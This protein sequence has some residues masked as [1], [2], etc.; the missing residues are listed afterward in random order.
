M[1]K[2]PFCAEEIQDGAIKCRYCKE[3]I[4]EIQP[5]SNQ[6]TPPEP[7]PVSTQTKLKLPSLPLMYW[8]SALIGV[9]LFWGAY[10]EHGTKAIM[11]AVIFAIL[12]P[13]VWI[14][15]DWI[16]GYAAPSVYFGTGFFDMIGKRFFWTYGPQIIS[17]IALLFFAVHLTISKERNTELP[18]TT[19]SNVQDVSEDEKLSH[20]QPEKPIP[21][22]SIEGPS[23]N[24]N[25]TSL[26]EQE[27]NIVNVTVQDFQKVFGEYGVSGAQDKRDQ[28]YV[29]AQSINERTLHIQC[30][31]FDA[32]SFLMVPAI[33]KAKGFPISQ[34]FDIVSFDKRANDALL[35]NYPKEEDRTRLIKEI[36]QAVKDA[37]YL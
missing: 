34:G 4:D 8:L 37:T 22:E 7:T 11:G 26:S 29:A 6:T 20:K 15:A 14:I 5:S 30:V 24:E 35:Q 28:C 12:S 13:I 21:P 16:R 36:L 27:I 18:Q 25:H 33:E 17:L 32:I 10:E 9:A 2:C 19:E 23:P 31:A 1:K 3:A